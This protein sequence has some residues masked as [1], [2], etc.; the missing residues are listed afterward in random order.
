MYENETVMIMVIGAL[1]IGWAIGFLSC[2]GFTG[3][4]RGGRQIQQQFEEL[5]K[6]QQAYQDQV[7]EH[8]T[9]TA[10]LLNQMANSYRDV[11]NHLAKG[12]NELSQNRI[13]PLQPLPEGRPVLEN[14][15]DKPPVTEPP[16]DY[17][18]RKEQEPGALHES[19]GLDRQTQ[20]PQE[21]VAPPYV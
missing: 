14:E 21:K 4:K 20:K 9:E 2:K 10:E 15:E 18:P 5:K 16:K 13:S 7:S 19:Y 12:A 1:L 8:F 17:A 3:G 11:H 6:E